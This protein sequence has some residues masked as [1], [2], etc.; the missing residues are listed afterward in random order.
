MPLLFRMLALLCVFLTFWIPGVPVA[1][2]A[3]VG[4]F[5]LMLADSPGLDLDWFPSPGDCPPAPAHAIISLGEPAIDE[6][7]TEELVRPVALWH[8][9]RGLRLD[10]TEIPRLCPVSDILAIRSLRV[11]LYL[12][13]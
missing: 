8:W 12:R 6:E 7:E 13:C 4:G 2:A 1:S 9:E 10:R 3:A 11:A 5:P